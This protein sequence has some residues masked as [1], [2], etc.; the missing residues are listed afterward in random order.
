MVRCGLRILV[1]PIRLKR[2]SKRLSKNSWAKEG[3]HDEDSHLP[4]RGG[5]IRTVFGGR[6]TR[7]HPQLA[8]F[9]NERKENV[10]RLHV[11]ELGRRSVRKWLGFGDPQPGAD[12]KCRH[13]STSYSVLRAV[14]PRRAS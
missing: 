10:R 7:G 2:C 5:I 14:L 3:S 6:A 13:L 11:R 8:Q 4:S 9:L 1:E 12:K